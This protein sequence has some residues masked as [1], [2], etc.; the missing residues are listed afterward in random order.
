MKEVY[1]KENK[2]TENFNYMSIDQLIEEL[3]K[4]DNLVNGKIILNTLLNESSKVIINYRGIEYILIELNNN[5]EYIELHSIEGGFVERFC[6]TD[7]I[8]LIQLKHIEFENVYSRS[9]KK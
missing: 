2:E 6:F 1:M 7:F 8:T 5:L 3:K 4:D 9:L